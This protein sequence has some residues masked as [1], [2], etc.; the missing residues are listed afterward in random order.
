MKHHSDPY[1][2]FKYKPSMSL[3]LGAVAGQYFGSVLEKVAQ[4]FQSYKVIL[5]IQKNMYL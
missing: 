4:R 3:A 2:P 1:K 5:C